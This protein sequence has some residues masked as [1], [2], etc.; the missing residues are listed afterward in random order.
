M[1]LQQIY[2][3]AIKKG[4]ESDLRGKEKVKKNLK[5]VKKKF[6][7]MDK[8]SQKEFDREKLTNPYSDTRILADNKRKSIKKVL[9]GIDM[10]GPEI[11]LADKMGDVDSV[12]SHHPHGKALA[13]LHGV[14]DLQAEVLADFGV[15]I[16]VGEDILRKRIS[17]VRRNISPIN[18]NRS[19]D[20][21]K[22]LDLDFMCVHTPA[23]NLG[24]KFLDNIFKKKKCEYVEDILQ[25][26]K[27]IPEYKEAVE[28]KAGPILFSGAEENHCG[29]VAVLEWT[30]GTSGAKEIFEKMSQAGIGTVIGMHI[31]ED[32]RR[33]AEK[34]HINVVIAGHMASDSLGMNL[35]LDELEKKGLE[36]VPMSGLIRVKRFTSK[37]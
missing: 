27:E 37:K 15:P 34:H 29:R 26:L 35:F 21:A 2:K 24:A 13:D 30:G 23:D 25:V 31:P 36:I 19:V 7:K 17:E 16:N 32:H 14:M 3:L 8:D 9:A 12:I 4:I 6:E 20:M 10:G 5:R 22:Y 18:H 33:E 11:L 1:T 28:H